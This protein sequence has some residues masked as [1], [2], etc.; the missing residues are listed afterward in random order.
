[1]EWRVLERPVGVMTVRVTIGFP[2]GVIS[3]RDDSMSHMGNC[4]GE[5][6]RVKCEGNAFLISKTLN[7]LE[8]FLNLSDVG[9]PIGVVSSPELI[10]HIAN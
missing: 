4:D 9:W 2:I 7:F 8:D 5:D 3:S 10:S 1:M 6:A